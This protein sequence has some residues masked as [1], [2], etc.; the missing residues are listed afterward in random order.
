MGEKC[1]K[2]VS[3]NKMYREVR[4]IGKSHSTSIDFANEL[5]VSEGLAVEHFA[6]HYHFNL[7]R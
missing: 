2:E 5:E 3:K 6:L 4:E 7:K 1:G